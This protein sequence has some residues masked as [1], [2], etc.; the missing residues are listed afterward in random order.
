VQLHLKEIAP[1]LTRGAMYESYNAIF[2][3]MQPVR[4]MLP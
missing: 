3:P 2:L 4:A 1:L